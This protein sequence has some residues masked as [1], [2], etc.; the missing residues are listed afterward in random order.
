[1]KIISL[2]VKLLILAL[3]LVL[4]LTNTNAVDFFYLP[5]QSVRLPLIVVMFGLFVVGTVFGIFAM[6]GRVL[7]LRGENSRLRREVEKTARLTT[8][9]LAAPAPADAAQK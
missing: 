7:R 5:G 1:M 3:L 8:S 2:I 4:A 9:D 6:F